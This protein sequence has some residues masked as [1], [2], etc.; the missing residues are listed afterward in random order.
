MQWQYQHYTFTL[1]K[2]CRNVAWLVPFL[3]RVLDSALNDT[4][5]CP[6]GDRRALLISLGG[7]GLGVAAAS[8]L[9]SPDTASS[10]RRKRTLGKD[11]PWRVRCSPNM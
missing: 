9:L 5:I 1:I 4:G 10:S 2:L 11:D 3:A 8:K 6:Q 7:L